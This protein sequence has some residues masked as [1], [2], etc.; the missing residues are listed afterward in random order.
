M[1][2]KLKKHLRRKDWEAEVNGKEKEK[3][4]AKE[5]EKEE[6]GEYGLKVIYEG[7]NPVVE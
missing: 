2:K 5:K 3:S 4:E 6:A 1:L 7:E